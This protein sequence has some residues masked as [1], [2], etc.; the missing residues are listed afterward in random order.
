[1][2]KARANVMTYQEF[3]QSIQYL[4]FFYANQEFENNMNNPDRMAV[5]FSYLQPY[6]TT[7]PINVLCKYYCDH[8][9]FPPRSPYDLLNSMENAVKDYFPDA[10]TAWK[11]LNDDSFKPEDDSLITRTIMIACRK[12]RRGKYAMFEQFKQEYDK[13]REKVFANYKRAVQDM[14]TQKAIPELSNIR[15]LIRGIEDD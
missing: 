6:M 11:M 10:Q 5:W 7:I 3:Q 4:V 8:N 9:E 14:Q 13:E 15:K 12:T 2:E 1:V